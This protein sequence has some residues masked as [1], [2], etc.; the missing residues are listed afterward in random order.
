MQSLVL[1]RKCEGKKPLGRTRHR[2]IILK[3]DHKEV[4]G[5]DMEWINLAE[6]SDKWRAL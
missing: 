6:D 4:G 5:E 2:W 3:V 1:V